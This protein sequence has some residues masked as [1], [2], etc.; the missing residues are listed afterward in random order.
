MNQKPTL[1]AL[2]LADQ[3][4]TD[5]ATGKHVIAGTFN[6]LFA[7]EF[8]AV[9]GR[10]TFVYLSLTNIRKKVEIRLRYVSLK[11]YSVLLEAT[12]ITI[13]CSDPLA[14]V[15]LAVQI[16]PFPMPEPGSY[17]FEVHSGGELIGSTRMLVQAKPE[18]PQ[19]EK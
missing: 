15:E 7:S 19:Q 18:A 2:L 9:F 5:R 17:A 13:E 10:A 8:P 6:G 4:Y 11:D 3:V 16:P 1:Q 12:P 14:T